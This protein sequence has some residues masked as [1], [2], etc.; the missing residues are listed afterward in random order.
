VR[1]E[2]LKLLLHQGLALMQNLFLIYLQCYLFLLLL[3][4]ENCIGGNAMRWLDNWLFDTFF[5]PWSDSFQE[6]FGKDCFWLAKCGYWCAGTTW[7]LMLT[8][9]LTTREHSAGSVAG[10]LFSG[11][12]VLVWVFLSIQWVDF[13]K[14]QLRG[15][16]NS[17]R[18]EMRWMFLRYVGFCMV[19]VAFYIVAVPIFAGDLDGPRGLSAVCSLVALFLMYGALYFVACT[20][21]PPKRQEAPLRGW[22]PLSWR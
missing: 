16:M 1:S 12:L 13:I 9:I 15:A 4:V 18:V 8:L 10:V 19:A 17:L 22:R 14:Q 2:Y 11:I 5:Q 20:P 7:V 3:P 6:R 21:A